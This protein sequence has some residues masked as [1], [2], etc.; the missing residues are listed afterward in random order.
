MKDQFS[1]ETDEDAMI[2]LAYDS[3]GHSRVQSEPPRIL[4]ASLDR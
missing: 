3:P 4:V 1:S 2:T